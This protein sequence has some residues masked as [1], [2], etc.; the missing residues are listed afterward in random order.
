MNIMQSPENRP[1]LVILGTGF[2]SFSLLKALRVNYYDVKV[3]SP[4]NHFLFTP[5]LPSTTVGTLEFRSI[6]EPIRQARPALAFFQATCQSLDPRQK[7]ITCAGAVD[8]KKFELPYDLLVIAVGAVGDTFRVPGV[9]EHAL[10]LKELREAR[11]IRQRIIECFERAGLPNVS[12]EERSHLLHFV[13]CGGGPT[14]V[15]FAAELHDLIREDLWRTYP[16]LVAKVRITLVEAGQEILNGFDAR[17]RDYAKN[18]FRRQGID[19]RIA[20]PVAAVEGEQLQLANGE[21]L[22]Y[23]LLLWSTGNAA[24]PLVEK[25]PFAKDRASRLLTDDF[26]R[27]REYPEIYA[28]GD[29]AII[30][31]HPLPATAQVATQQGKYLA[32]ALNRLAIGKPAAP[33]RYRHLGMLA[34]IGGN[35]AL[36]DLENFKGRGLTAWLFW[37]SAYLTRLVSLKNKMQVVF[38]WFKAK[39]F[40]RDV[41][42]F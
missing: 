34:Y 3:V 11:A 12:T 32:T 9:R 33:F 21:W 36:A 30:D 19:V 1:H 24:T 27:I 41:S 18:H 6:I 2:A 17:L 8:G 5:L 35:R 14:G 42:H 38:D 15:E 10:F 7:F 40:G 20:S 22:P 28:L 39:V 31:G 23:G 16:Q 37:R 4:R 29:C 13:I 25:L 26:V